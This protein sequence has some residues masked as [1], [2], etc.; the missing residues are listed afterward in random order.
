MINIKSVYDPRHKD[1]G[2][3]VLV[4][5]VWPKGFPKGKTAG[6]DWMKSMG[7]S[8]NLRGWMNRNPRKTAGF[9]DRYL[10]E[11]G[12]NEKDVNRVCALLKE[13]GTVTILKVPTYE[14]WEIVETLAKYLRAH[15]D[16]G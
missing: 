4:E 8:N 16:V 13:H 1:D 14:Q 12:H 11:L 6:C 15:C 7:P 10:A 2:H 5:P 3:R 9:Q